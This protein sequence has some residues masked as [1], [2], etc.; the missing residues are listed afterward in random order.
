M[1]NIWLFFLKTFE[2]CAV[3]FKLWLNMI[4]LVVIEIRKRLEKKERK[5]KGRKKEE[6]EEKK[7]QNKPVCE[8]L[9]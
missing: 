8:M 2:V 1:V 9:A 3:M 5:K 6:E 4:G 7:V